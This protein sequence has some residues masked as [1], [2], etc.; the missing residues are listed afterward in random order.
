M[1]LLSLNIIL[2]L[3]LPSVILQ[4]YLSTIVI[5]HIA[6]VLVKKFHREKKC[7]NGPILMKFTGLTMFSTILIS[8]FDRMMEW[9][10]EDLVTV[11]ASGNN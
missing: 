4:S 10:F 8:W 6:L 5:F 11:P 1:D 9:A 7:G 2:L 3:E